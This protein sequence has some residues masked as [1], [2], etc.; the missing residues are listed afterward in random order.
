M[1]ECIINTIDSI[2][3]FL[4]GRGVEKG[5]TVDAFSVNKLSKKTEE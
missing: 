4:T 5:E 3:C 1:R 2:K